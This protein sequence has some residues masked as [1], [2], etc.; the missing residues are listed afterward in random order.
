MATPD[1]AA[2]KAPPVVH[3]PARRLT[4]NLAAGT[5]TSNGGVLYEVVPTHGAIRLRAR[6]KTATNGGTIDLFAVGPDFNPDQAI[7]GVVY[8]SLVGTI[9]TTGNPTQVNV[10]AGTEAKIDY[11]CYGEAYVIVKFTGTVGAGTVTYCDVC[12]LMQS[13]MSH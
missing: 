10:T 6:I 1:V 2:K 13:A 9:Y 11:D 5:A 8:G 12:E 4:G 7:A 3:R